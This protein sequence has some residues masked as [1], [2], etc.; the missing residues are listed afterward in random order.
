MNDALFE[1][2]GL[3]KGEIK[4]YTALLS[5]GETTISPIVTHGKVT[6]SKVYDILEKL[7]EKGFVGYK[8]KDNIKHFFINDPKVIKDYLQRKEVE[9]QQTQLEVDKILPLLESKRNE[10]LTNRTAEIYQGLRGMQTV[11]E[12]LLLTLK[13]GQTLLVLGAPKL[14]NEKWEG[15][16]LEFHKKR[17][18][19]GVNM[20]IIYNANAKQFGKIRQQMKLTTV[21]YMPSDIDSP[22]WIDIFDSAVMLS[23][24]INNEPIS[25][26]IRSKELT[27]SFRSYFEMIWN[28]SIN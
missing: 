21:K 4:V 7:I 3:T 11:R 13:K 5:L 25:F 20:R 24:I 18:A 19:N 26:V 23:V 27:E 12:E 1:K 17:I 2:I 9:L 15:W 6:K 16:L 28:I 22:T 8:L 14:A 10:L